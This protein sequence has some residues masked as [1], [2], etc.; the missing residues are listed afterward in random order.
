MQESSKDMVTVNI[1]GTG[2]A[3]NTECICHVNLN[4][5]IGENVSYSGVGDSV[6]DGSVFAFFSSRCHHLQT[7]FQLGIEERDSR[8]QLAPLHVTTL[9]Q[10]IQDLEPF[11]ELTTLLMQSLTALSLKEYVS[12]KHLYGFLRDQA[13]LNQV[14]L[15]DSTVTVNVPYPTVKVTLVHDMLKD[16]NEGADPQHSLHSMYLNKDQELLC[17]GGDMINSKGEGD[18][19]S[20]PLLSDTLET[21]EDGFSQLLRILPANCIVGTE[22]ATSK[23]LLNF[24]EK[25]GSIQECSLPMKTIKRVGLIH[26]YQVNNILKSPLMERNDMSET[27]YRNLHE[28]FTKAKMCI[29]YMPALC[30]KG[31]GDDVGDSMHA[32]ITTLCHLYELLYC[33]KSCAKHTSAHSQ[34][35]LSVLLIVGL[36]VGLSAAASQCLLTSMTAVASLCDCSSKLRNMLLSSTNIVSLLLRQLW[37]LRHILQLDQ[38]MIQ[39]INRPRTKLNLAT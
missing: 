15:L 5:Y 28:H 31:V 37:E 33:G 16:E 36:N 2:K 22:F 25:P 32:F 29:K 27:I 23:C 10:S 30:L 19:Q 14:S 11:N 3:P 8:L 39:N 34:Y 17:S 20:Q 4:V 6:S 1:S 21:T 12:L 24:I 9:P 35:V 7:V 13:K 38:V 18:V 26:F